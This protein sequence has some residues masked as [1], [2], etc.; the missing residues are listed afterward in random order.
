MNTTNTT[1]TATEARLAEIVAR[2]KQEILADIA[3]GVVPETVDTFG[4]LHSYVD[5]NYYGGL[6][7]EGPTTDFFDFVSEPTPADPHARVNHIQDLLDSWL[8]A[9]RVDTASCEVCDADVVASPDTRRAFADQRP[10]ASWSAPSRAATRPTACCS[11]T[12]PSTAPRPSL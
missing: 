8:Q 3:Q 2:A 5:A 9:G 4:D 10:T 12:S 6:C 1:D 11:T 7:D